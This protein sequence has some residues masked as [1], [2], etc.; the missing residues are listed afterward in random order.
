MLYTVS[1]CCDTNGDGKYKL[2]RLF[3]GT[4][5][6]LEQKLIIVFFP[7]LNWLFSRHRLFRAVCV[8]AL[9]IDEASSNMNRMQS[10]NGWIMH[11]G[12]AS[13][14]EIWIYGACFL[15]GTF[16]LSFTLLPWS[17]WISTFTSLPPPLQ[18][19]RPLCFHFASPRI[20]GFYFSC[21]FYFCESHSSERWY[22]CT[23]FL[24]FMSSSCLHNPKVPCLKCGG[25]GGG[26]SDVYLCTLCARWF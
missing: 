5:E 15:C 11:F 21:G 8:C 20:D 12:N 17:T 24:I 6:Q 16:S 1:I 18:I 19:L 25:G 10:G 13:I 26:G 9:S 14:A 3:P 7:W 23:I 22:Y 2:C 4:G